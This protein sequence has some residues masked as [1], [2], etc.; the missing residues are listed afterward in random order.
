MISPLMSGASFP[1]LAWIL[2]ATLPAI[3]TSVCDQ[4]GCL[5]QIIVSIWFLSVK[6]APSLQRSQTAALYEGK[7]EVE[8]KYMKPKAVIF[9]ENENSSNFLEIKL[10]AFA[11]LFRKHRFPKEMSQLL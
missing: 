10:A 7:N 1:L 3:F 6:N 5:K 8:S 4:R 2:P 9:T 11:K